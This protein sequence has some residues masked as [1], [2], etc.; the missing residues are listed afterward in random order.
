RAGSLRP[1]FKL[2]SKDLLPDPGRPGGRDSPQGA[3]HAPAVGQ[4]VWDPVEAAP[5]EIPA[6]RA[7][8]LGRRVRCG[9]RPL[10][11]ADARGLGT[12]GR[13]LSMSLPKTSRY[14]VIGAGIHG[15]STA[16]N[17]A[18]ELQSRGIGWG[19]SIIVLDKTN[20]GAG[21]SGIACGVV[22]NNYFQP[23]MR[24]LMEHSVSVW[25]SDPDAFSYHG[26]GYMQLAPE[27]MHGDV[28]QI[29]EEQRAIGYPS[30]L[31]EGETD[32]RI[33]MEELFSDW[34]ARNITC[35]LHEKRGGYANNVASMNGL[36]AKAKAAGVRVFPGTKVLGFVRNSTGAVT[37]VETDQGVVE[38]ES[39]IVAVGPWVRDF[40][41]MLDLPDAID[42]KWDGQVYERPMWT[43]WC[44]EEGT[45]KL[46]PEYL[47]TNAGAMPPVIHVD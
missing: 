46:D 7:R 42:V 27:A 17:L 15:L 12:T 36:A 5:R 41:S 33:Y 19:D 20:V 21:A 47:R 18:E 35:V 9:R 24:E 40:W 26:V 43:Y 1:I 32:S 28:A 29:Y 14:V 44:L 13:P 11:A 37:A 16:W 39:V 34:Q 3:D 4:L 8:I 6:V 22:R 30:T 25:E 10:G 2:V 31:V 23:A 38:C 45:L